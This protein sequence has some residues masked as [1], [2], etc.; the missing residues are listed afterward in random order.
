MGKW[1]NGNDVEKKIKYKR[2]TSNISNIL[3]KFYYYDNH[4]FWNGQIAIKNKFD[5]EKYLVAVEFIEYGNLDEKYF[6][7]KTKIINLVKKKYPS[8]IIKEQLVS[9]KDYF[10][11]NINKEFENVKKII[12]STK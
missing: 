2:Y 6:K 7:T 12:N 9:G 3:K 11:N 1:K 4:I 8:V 10:M 5:I